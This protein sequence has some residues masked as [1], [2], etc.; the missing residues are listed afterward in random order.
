MDDENIFNQH[1]LRDTDKPIS[2]RTRIADRLKVASLRF[3]QLVI[4]PLESRHNP[5]IKNLREMD[6]LERDRVKF[7][8]YCVSFGK[9]PYRA[10]AL[11][12]SYDDSP[13]NDE[14][15]S[16][17]MLTRYGWRKLTLKGKSLKHI[18]DDI[19]YSY[20]DHSQYRDCRYEEKV[21]DNGHVDWHL[22]F[23]NVSISDYWGERID[24]FTIRGSDEAVI[25]INP[26]KNEV[27]QTIKDSKEH[28][29]LRA[30]K[31]EEIW[32]KHISRNNKD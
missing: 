5:M 17:M 6:K 13:D 24:G 25:D 2:I 18:K 20:Q 10:V 22:A 12:G 9:G 8:R 15:L 11:I 4:D 23:Q 29:I 3:T 7:G 32:N 1:K 27:E 26:N 14:P 30:R 21:Y 31:N 16:V 28:V 19:R